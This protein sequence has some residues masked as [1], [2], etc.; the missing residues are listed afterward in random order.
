MMRPALVIAVSLASLSGLASPAGAQVA[1]LVVYQR[2]LADV[3]TWDAIVSIHDSRGRASTTTGVEINTIGCGGSCV[4]T[5]VRGGLTLTTLDAHTR[6]WWDGAGTSAATSLAT[7]FYQTGMT[8]VSTFSGDSPATGD[9]QSFSVPLPRS[10]AAS[11]A[12]APASR[13]SQD[14]PADGRRIVTFYRIAPDGR[15]IVH[16]RITYTRRR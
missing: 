6:P 13:V 4:S 1:P 10:Q 11:V 2:S 7:P 12:G 3:G 5:S 9:L 14:R 16:L 15:E 8:Q